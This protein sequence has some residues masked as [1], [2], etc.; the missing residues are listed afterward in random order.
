MVRFEILNIW[1]NCNTV[2][3]RWRSVEPAVGVPTEVFPEEPVTG[4]VVLEVVPNPASTSQPWQIQ[5]TYSEVRALMGKAADLRHAASPPVSRSAVSY[6]SRPVLEPVL[7]LLTTLVQQRRMAIRSR[8]LHPNMLIGVG[9]REAVESHLVSFMK[10]YMELGAELGYSGGGYFLS[11]I[12]ERRC[13]LTVT[14]T[15][16]SNPNVIVDIV[17]DVTNFASR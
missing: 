16:L 9:P 11:S 12:S 10:E 17:E 7:T 6:L 5:T 14:H 15:Y 13:K 1:N 3:L 2:I 4:I 8:C